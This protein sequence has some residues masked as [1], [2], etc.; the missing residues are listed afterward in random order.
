MRY[1]SVPLITLLILIFSQAV[2]AHHTA[3][4]DGM[5]KEQAA[6]LWGFHTIPATITVDG[7][8]Y[9]Y[10][11]NHTDVTKIDNPAW[12]KVAKGHIKAG[13]K[14]P[15]A[16]VMHGCSGIIRNPVA[17]RLFLM[18]LGF[19]VIEPDSFARPGHSC[20]VRAL[21]A[22]MAD[23]GH[24]Y[25]MIRELPWADQ[26]RI[27]L[28]GISQGGAAVARWDQPG[29]AAHIILANNCDGGLPG[30]P[31]GIPVLAVVGEDDEYYKGSSCDV[32][33]TLKG[34]QSIVIPH[35]PHGII[36][37]PEVEQAMKELFDHAGLL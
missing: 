20:E 21:N 29:F 28:V 2:Q 23:L 11:Y 33:R 31:E 14:T 22:R 16:L 24:A 3:L 30:A 5:S 26:N 27:V 19:A 6:W 9:W 12:T 17:Y 36:A 10:G 35:A 13:A 4:P 7:S 25:K 15:V 8:P 34:S 37:Y 18:E 32:K 1:L